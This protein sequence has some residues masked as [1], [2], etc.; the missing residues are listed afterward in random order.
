LKTF[1]HLGWHVPEG[2]TAMEDLPLPASGGVGEPTQV[3]NRPSL[4]ELAGM[5]PETLLAGASPALRAALQRH[6][7][8]ETQGF[9]GAGFHSFIE[10]D[11]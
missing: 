11:P 8:P 3:G 10:T 4:I 5:D 1:A 2:G 9:V 7:S 6:F